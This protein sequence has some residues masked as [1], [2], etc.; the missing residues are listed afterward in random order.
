MLTILSIM[1]LLSS[2]PNIVKYR[3]SWIWGF[4][5][6]KEYLSNIVLGGL[7][8]HGKKNIAGDHL[9]AYFLRN[10]MHAGWKM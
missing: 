3:L 5:I 2:F 10:I 9:Y 7:K 6:H 1:L 4:Q 8:V